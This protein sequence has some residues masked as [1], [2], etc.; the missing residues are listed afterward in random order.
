MKK[1]LSPLSSIKL[2]MASAMGRMMPSCEHVS[3]LISESMDETL[4]VRQ[5]VAIKMHLVFCKWCRRYQNQIS[6][7]RRMIQ[8]SSDEKPSARNGILSRET[9]DRINR[10]LQQKDS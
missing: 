3:Q 5:Q 9:R 6:V 2:R 4:T 8:D 10:A 1:R 7:I